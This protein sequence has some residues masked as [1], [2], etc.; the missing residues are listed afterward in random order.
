VNSEKSDNCSSRCEVAVSNYEALMVIACLA[1][2][3]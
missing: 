2:F 3:T 1:V